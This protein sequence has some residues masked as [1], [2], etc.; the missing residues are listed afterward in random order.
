MVACEN[1][2][3]DDFPCVEFV[4]RGK[5]DCKYELRLYELGAS[6]EVA[7]I[8]SIIGATGLDQEDFG[9]GI[10]EQPR[11]DSAAGGARSDDD[12]IKLPREGR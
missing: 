7:D 4:H 3:L 12:I 5:T 8:E 6:G 9:L 10:R 1:G 11:H 2:H